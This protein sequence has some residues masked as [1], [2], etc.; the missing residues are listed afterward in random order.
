[1]KYLFLIL[2]LTNYIFAYSASDTATNLNM[3]LNDFSFAM[4]NI[5]LFLGLIFFLLMS[6][7][8]IRIGSR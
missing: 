5:G 8:A 2:L 6:Y 3:T 7:L 4:A 1:M